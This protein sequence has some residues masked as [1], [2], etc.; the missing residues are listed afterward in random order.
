MK[1]WNEKFGNKIININ[2]EK[3]VSD[4]KKYTKSL[5]KDLNLNWEENI[6]NY[7]KNNDSPVETASLHQ[8][9]G[10]ILKNTSEQWKEYKNYLSEM[11]NILKINNI[12]F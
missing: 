4:Y 10:K 12:N 9:R 1:F 8:V 2:Y 3:F 7:N 11:Q 6:K 5:V